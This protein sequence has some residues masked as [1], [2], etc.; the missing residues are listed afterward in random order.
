M[1]VHYVPGT[2]KAQDTKMRGI[3]PLTILEGLR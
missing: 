1:S 2:I 3:Q